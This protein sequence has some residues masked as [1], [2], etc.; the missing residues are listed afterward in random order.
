MQY[1]PPLGLARVGVSIDSERLLVLLDM[2]RMF[3][4][5]EKIFSASFEEH[6]Q[7]RYCGSGAFYP[8]PY[9]CES[10]AT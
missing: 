2:D 10:A 3:S 9:A 8:L 1:E 5:A 7:S 4:Q 6:R